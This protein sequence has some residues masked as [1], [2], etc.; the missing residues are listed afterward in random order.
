MLGVTFQAAETNAALGAS[1]MVDPPL[2]RQ[3]VVKKLS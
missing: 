1:E 3:A 2:P